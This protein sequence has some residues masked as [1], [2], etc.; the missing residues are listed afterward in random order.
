MEHGTENQSR[1]KVK[2]PAEFI[3]FDFEY[4]AWEKSDERNWSGPGEHREIIQIGAIKVSATT[5][6]ETDS[7]LD[8]V[9]PEKNPELSDFIIQLTGITQ[10]DIESR[11]IPFSQALKKLEEFIGGLRAYCWGRDIE[12][13]KEN[14][15][16]LQ[17]ST[18]LSS[19]HLTNLRPLMAPIFLNLGVDIDAYSSG[20]L[21]QAFEDEPLLKAHD[22]LNDMRNLLSAIRYVREYVTIA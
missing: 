17:V 22:A 19:D 2:F 15:E 11:G 4:T 7:L 3:L 5:L 6:S 14:C 1:L 8:Y 18:S 21:I 9:R 12:V 20:T 10:T 13:L 16:L